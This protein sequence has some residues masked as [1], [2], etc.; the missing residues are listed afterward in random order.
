MSRFY[1]SLQGNRGA[2]TRQ[3]TTKSGIHGHIRGW[4]I[5]AEVSVFPNQ[6]DQDV[7]NVVITGGSRNSS[8]LLDLGTFKLVDGHAVKVS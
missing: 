2:A 7:V 6:L 1:G 5:G 3:G 4:S 8:T